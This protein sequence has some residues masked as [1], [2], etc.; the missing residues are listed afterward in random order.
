MRLITFFLVVLY[1]SQATVA[2]VT[3]D[4][5]YKDDGSI[6][7][8]ATNADR[9]PYTILIDMTEHTNL[10]PIG[11]SGLVVARPGRSKVSTLK[12]RTEG[13][14]TSIRYSYSILKGDFYAKSKDEPVYL[15]P[16]PE[17]TLTTGVR[18]THIQNRLQPEEENTEYVG[19]SF[20]F[21]LPTEVLAPRKGV[22]TEIRMDQYDEKQNL[23]YDRSENY[24]ELFHEDGS[25]TKIMVLKPG[26]L[27]VEVGQEVFPGDVLA[28]SAGEEYNSGLHVR[29]VNMKPIKDGTSKLKY[30]NKPMS[31]ISREGKSD[32]PEMKKVE[33]VYPE[34][35]ITAEMSKKEK[36]AFKA[37]N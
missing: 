7:L 10:L 18:M 34:E 19:I 26:S 23:D 2:Q 17:G 30:Q 27:K 6:E 36:K 3:M 21:D 22:V 13:Q 32:F 24:I 11:S 14:A 15:I 20:R 31:F 4:T 28:E 25:L 12:R 1:Y 29:L 33:V 16:L 9:V 37:G 35:I 5:E 8:Y